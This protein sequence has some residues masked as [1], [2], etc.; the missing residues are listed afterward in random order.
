MNAQLATETH[1]QEKVGFID[2]KF[3]M[4]LDRQDIELFIRDTE[5]DNTEYFARVFQDDGSFQVPGCDLSAKVRDTVKGRLELKLNGRAKPLVFEDAHVVGTVS[6]VTFKTGGHGQLVIQLRVDAGKHLE[7]LAKL[8][9][10]GEC[11]LE[12]VE[13]AG[14]AIG[15]DGGN[16][17]EA[18]V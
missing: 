16:Q 18:P 9:I 6:A 15:G 2:L 14:N 5:Q 8:P 1:G 13:Y 12:F 4:L 10:V 17:Q 7:A 3:R 11:M